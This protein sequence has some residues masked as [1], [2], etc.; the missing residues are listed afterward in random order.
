MLATRA[1]LLCATSSRNNIG[2]PFWFDLL[3]TRPESVGT[4]W[5][6]ACAILGS[7]DLWLPHA[8]R[9]PTASTK[10]TKPLAVSCP[11]SQPPAGTWLRLKVLD[12]D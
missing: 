6:S 4:L 12:K 3:T 5:P 11:I 9:M 8:G 10:A 7:V 2:A 1:G